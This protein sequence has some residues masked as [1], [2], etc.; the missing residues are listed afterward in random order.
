MAFMRDPLYILMQDG[1][2]TVYDGPGVKGFNA[3]GIWPQE[4]FDEIVMMRYYNMTEEERRATINRVLETQL[5]TGA[6]GIRKASGL[7]TVMERV[8]ENVSWP[9]NSGGLETID[10]Y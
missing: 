7:S 4:L 1:E 2:V 9:P 8:H 3:F 6:D 5:E 10:K